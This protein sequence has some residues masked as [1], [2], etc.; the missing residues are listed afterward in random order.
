[1]GVSPKYKIIVRLDEETKMTFF[2]MILLSNLLFLL[3]WAY[4]MYSEVTNTWRNKIEKV[5]LLVWLWGK[6]DKFEHE[7]RRREIKD[8]HDMLRQEFETNLSKLLTLLSSDPKYAFLPTISY[9]CIERI[10]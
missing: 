8:Q 6:K 7:K 3:Y 9:P 2:I 4:K 1:M 10:N 5:Y